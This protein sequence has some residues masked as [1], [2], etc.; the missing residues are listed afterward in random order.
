MNTNKTLTA[1]MVLHYLL[2]LAKRKN[3]EHIPFMF[4]EGDV[5]IQAQTQHLTLIQPEK[6]KDFSTIT[7]VTQCDECIVIGSIPEI[8]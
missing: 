8:D 7:Y 4:I 2:E 6:D 3:L 1:A 5:A